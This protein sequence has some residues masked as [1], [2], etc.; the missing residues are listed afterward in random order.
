MV[1]VK[2]VASQ[3][4]LDD[5]IHRFDEAGG[6]SRLIFA[7]HSPRG[8]LAP[9]ERADVIVWARSGLAETTVRIGLVEWLIEKVG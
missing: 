9:P 1:Q 8:L 6:Y 2:S 4:V 7:C 3:S 5:Y